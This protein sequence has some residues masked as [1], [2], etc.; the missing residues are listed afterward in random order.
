VLSAPHFDPVR[1]LLQ[2]Q[3]FNLSELEK[4]GQLV[5]ENAQNLLGGFM[6]DGILEEHKFKCTIAGM[7]EKAKMGSGSR[8][9]GLVRV[10]GEMVDL[11]WE[12]HPKATKRLEELW[13]EV[14]QIHSFPLLCAYSLVG[15]TNVLPQQ[16]ISCHSHDIS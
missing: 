8:K 11:I 15:K 3:G 4:T 9:A 7:I 6:F 14:I 13:N 2:R 16:L 10:F 5:C 12:P 1:E